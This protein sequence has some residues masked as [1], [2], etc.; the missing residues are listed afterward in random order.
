MGKRTG[1]L[2]SLLPLGIFCAAYLI[3]LFTVQSQY[4]QLMLILVAVWAVMGISWNVLSGYSGLISFGH[5]S[6]FGLGAFTVVLGQIYL[7]LTPWLGIPLAGIIGAAAGILIGLPTF[8]LRGHY[9]ALAMLAYPLALLY[10]FEWLGYQEVAIP[11]ER[12]NPVAWM[13]FDNQ[14]IYALIALGLLIA[15]I[16][17]SRLI[18][19]SRFGM[20][21]LAIKQNELAAEAAGIET[22]KWK[23]RAIA[24]SGAIAGTIGGFY[25]IVLLV[26]TPDTVFGMLTSAQALIVTL[27]GGV[28]TVWGPIIGAAILIPLA[29]T[30]HAEVG[31]LLHGI[32]GVVYGVAIIIIILVAPE[33]LMWKIRDIMQ[34]RSKSAEPAEGTAV[35]DMVASP[36][37]Q[38][39]ERPDAMS[40]R[41]MLEVRNLS[42]SF[43]GLR[44]VQNVSFS[45][46]EGA[47]IGIIGPNGA[48]KT[49]LFNLLNGFQKPDEGEVIFEGKSL[50]GLA[51]SGV[52]RRGIGRTFQVARP[53]KR[54]SVL[55]NVLIGAYVGAETDEIALQHAREAVAL[56]GLESKADRLAGG[57]TSMEQ[58][59]MEL[60]RA[61]A[62]K[63]KML[64]LDE[65]LAGL[66]GVEVNEMINVIRR[67]SDT[68][69][70]IVIIEHTMQAM[71]RLADH[72]IVLDHGA[73]LTEG[74]PRDV[75]QEDEVIEAYLGKRWRQRA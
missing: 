6:F 32:Q 71:L 66:G 59:L 51:P 15:A 46:P 74:K 24:V 36:D 53:F 43:G 31:N 8:R 56:V 47:V 75:V 16:I 14:R 9:F 38:D 52:C 44:A 60:A 42:K 58:R 27:F 64:F 28:G 40:G 72:F 22:R 17:V 13:Q 73:L 39:D 10:I 62:G 26:I 23:L 50:L 4:Y 19:T 69:I 5:A 70:T 30:L 57:L 2:S 68:G 45:V 61:L 21:L 3:L 34:A 29:E 18:E 20:S 7:G 1:F 33:G 35:A 63:P 49:T 48:G 37:T 25:A 11:M 12:E 54:L 55:D 67:L 41:T 65:T